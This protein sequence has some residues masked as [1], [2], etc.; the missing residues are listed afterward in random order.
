M[1]FMDHLRELRT[2]IRNAAIA[3]LCAVLATYAVAEYLFVW[4]ARPLVAAWSAA[5]LGAPV[6]HFKSPVEPLFVYIKI[7]LIG[8]IFLASPFIFWQLWRFVAPGLYARERRAVLP[9]VGASVLCFVGGAAFGYTLVFPALFKFL[10]GFAR[11]NLGLL[12]RVF[13]GAVKFG[14]GT[15]VQL[16]PTIMM[17]EYLGL[18]AKTLI[19]FGL[20]FELPIFLLFLG[21]VGIVDHRKLLRFSRYAVLAIFIVSAIVTPDPTATTQVMLALPLVALYYV[22]VLLVYIFGRRRAAATESSPA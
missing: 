19:I 14:V 4:M 18:A 9:F 15:P 13:G 12:E 17:E 2:R 1:G 7:S 11:I 16:Q 5:G 21:L 10:F 20:C 8:G 3:Y 22:G 6:L